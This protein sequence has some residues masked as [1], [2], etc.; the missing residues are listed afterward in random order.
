MFQFCRLQSA[1]EAKIK[2]YM[3]T[4][5]EFVLMS[6]NSCWNAASDNLF[7]RGVRINPPMLKRR[8]T[9]AKR[10]KRYYTLETWNKRCCSW[11]ILLICHQEN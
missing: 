1:S 11:K 3:F 9:G 5:N 4:P 6:I 8:S 10:A 7:L 2:F